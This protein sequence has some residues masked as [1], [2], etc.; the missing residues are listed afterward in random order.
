LVQGEG[1]IRGSVELVE[2]LGSEKIVYVKAH[3]AR[4]VAKAPPDDKLSQGDNIS[5]SFNNKGLHFFHNGQRI[6]G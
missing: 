1:P 4:L 2:H 6:S 3:D 5:L